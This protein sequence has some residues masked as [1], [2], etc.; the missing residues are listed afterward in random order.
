MTTC[1]VRMSVV[2]ALVRQGLGAAGVPSNQIVA[3]LA[4]FLSAMVMWPVWTRAW[5]E[6]VTP[7]RTGAIP[8]AEAF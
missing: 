3:S 2:L 7:Y 6:G 1:F 4:I 8:A 5:N